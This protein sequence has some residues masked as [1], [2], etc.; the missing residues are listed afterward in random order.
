MRR[1]DVV[2][3]QPLAHWPAAERAGIRGVITDIDDTLTTDGTLAPDTRA[4]LQA[5]AD[6][7]LPVL[8]VTGR[9]VG[10]SLPW[11]SGPEAWP[12][13]GIVAENGAVALQASA[14]GQIQR[15]YR[16]DAATRAAHWT[17]LQAALHAVEAQL[18]GA[19]RASDSAGRET[20]IAIDHSEHQRL[21]LAQINAVVQALQAHGLHTTVSSIHINAW[22][23]GHNKW[24]GAQWAVRIWLQRELAHELAHWVY[25]GDSSN[26]AVMFE[27]MAHSVGVANVARF[28]PDLRHAPH[29]VCRAER[30]AGF[31]ELAHALLAARA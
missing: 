8:A 30:G 18:P 24:V 10:W 4:A 9:P 31:A 15:W 7:G 13:L 26:D 29:W 12:L 23:G 19:R 25:V 5:L 1:A 27:H 21:D 14:D 2:T 17:R 6:A 22:C 11:L 20:D 3:P 16:D 28:L